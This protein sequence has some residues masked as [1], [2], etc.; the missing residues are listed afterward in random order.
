M[1]NMIV[2]MA[3]SGPGEA[4]LKTHLHMKKVQGIKMGYGTPIPGEDILQL[5]VPVTR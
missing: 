2:K 1:G 3:W 4:I 5:P